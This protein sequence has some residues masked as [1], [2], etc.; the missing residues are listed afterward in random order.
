MT[1]DLGTQETE[2]EG[3]I[4][5]H[6]PTFED[7][8]GSFSEVYNQDLFAKHGLPISWPQDNHSF[9]KF[10]V[11]RGLHVQSEDPQGKL[12]R[13]I[14]GT[15]MDVCLDLRP[16]SATFKKYT[17]QLLFGTRALYLPPGTAHGF[18]CFSKEAHVYYKCTSLYRPDKDGGV[19]WNDPENGMDWGGVKPIVSAKDNALPKLSDYIASRG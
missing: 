13:A 12:V 7:N 1:R 4:L 14:T 8:R 9:S 19:L 5:I 3:C 17:A 11:L 10:N 16:N 18:Y 15:I 2:V 6:V